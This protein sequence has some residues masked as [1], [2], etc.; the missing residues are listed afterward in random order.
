MI[1]KSYELEPIQGDK[2]IA[3]EP[4]QMKDSDGK[5]IS[6]EF[7]EELTVIEKEVTTNG[8]LIITFMN[9]EDREIRIWVDYKWLATR[10]G[11]D[12]DSY[13]KGGY[14]LFYSYVVPPEAMVDNSYESVFFEIKAG[15][16]NNKRVLYSVG[17]SARQKLKVVYSDEMSYLY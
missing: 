11:E 17:S 12:G 9:N 15:S 16:V 7:G 2:M 13:P 10:Y 1:F 4:I 8:H 14:K 5:R 3:Y 6:I